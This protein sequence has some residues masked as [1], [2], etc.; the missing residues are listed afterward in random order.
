[1]LTDSEKKAFNYL[2]RLSRSHGMKSMTWS[3][4][5]YQDNDVD[6]WEF[7]PS[8]YYGSRWSDK[9]RI[10]IPAAIQNELVAWYNREGKEA[11]SDGMDSLYDE[12]PN[13]PTW[14]RAE[15]ILNFN[16]NVI[17]TEG[18]Y[19]YSSEAS[20]QTREGSI[21]HLESI[22]ELFKKEYPNI[23]RFRVNYAGG[24]DSGYV[25]DYGESDD[26]DSIPVPNDFEELIYNHLPGGWEIN[27]GSAGYCDF[28]FDD[29]TYT[30][31]HIEYFDETLNGTFSEE[32][33]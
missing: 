9:V 12:L 5:D 25:E 3:I 22:V 17:R 29:M 20:P 16:E 24:G 19:Q 15:I 33:F 18:E 8:E 4:D 10:D 28:N 11:I 30:I 1:M 27:E 23:R 26:G 32:N 13:D 21:S 7:D 14:S 6:N 2:S 31:N